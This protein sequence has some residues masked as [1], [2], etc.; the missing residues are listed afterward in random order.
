MAEIE[1]RGVGQGVGDV[2]IVVA[3]TAVLWLMFSDAWL[4]LPLR[5]FVTFVHEAGHGVMAMLLGYDVT[6]L[7]INPAGGGLT[8]WR[9]DVTTFGIVMVGSAGYVGAAVVGGLMLASCRRLRQGR[10]AIGGVAV[11][12]AVIAVAWVPWRFDPQGPLGAAT[13]SGSG[14]GRFT[15]L[16][17]L[18]SVGV[19]V[20]L[21]AQRSAQVR[22]TVV[23]VLATALCLAAVSDLR[24]VLSMSTRGGHSDA[25]LLASETFLPAAVWATLWL[26]IGL[27]ACGSAVWLLVRPAPDGTAQLSP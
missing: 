4:L 8:F 22:R 3:A 27:A 12:M 13:G 17:C 16:F 15:W 21:A 14:D 18:V 26:L 5:W 7:T 6:S 9:G 10:I 24:G 19:L 25:T 1:R 20:G 23:A 11:I 2:R